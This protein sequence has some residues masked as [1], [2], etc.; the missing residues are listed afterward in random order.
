MGQSMSRGAKYFSYPLVVFVG[1]LPPALLLP[2]TNA[3]AADAPTSK[4]AAP[5]TPKKTP[6]SGKNTGK[7]NA[8]KGSARSA[9]TTARRQV[10]GGPTSDDVSAGHESPELRALREAER[11]LFPPASPAGGGAWPTELPSPLS[12]PSDRPHVH[13]SG[14][15]PSPVP[16]APPMSEGGKDL[17]WMQNLQLP[18]FPIRW[19]PRV[20]RYLEFFKDDPRGRSS[21]TI[22][23]RR[24]GRFRQLMSRALRKK[25]VPEDLFWLS[26]IESGFDPAARSPVGA[27]GLWQFMPETGKQYGLLQDRWLDQRLQPQAA[28]DAAADFL[29]DL[30]RRFGSWELAMASYNMGYAGVISMVRKYNTNDYW[31]LSRLEGALPWETTLYVPKIMAAAIVG[32]NLATFG[33][34]DVAVESAADYE[35]VLVPPGTA[36]STV[37]TACGVPTKEITDLNLELRAQRTPPLDPA[38]PKP[39][40]EATTPVGYP[41][42]VPVG[43]GQQGTQNLA[44]QKKDASPPER[45]VVRFGESLEQISAAR[46]VPLA[47]IVELNAIAQ[48]EVVRGGTVILL[49]SAKSAP[50]TTI[51]ASTPAPAA[52]KPIVIVPADVFV[53]PDRRRVFYRVIVGDTLRDI[54][55]TFKISVDEIRRWNEIDPVGRLQEGMTLQLFVPQDADL[56]KVVAMAETDVRTVPVGTDDFFTYWEG[57]KG[58]RRI[59]IPAKTGDTLE[60]IGKRYGVTPASMERVNRRN[61]GEALKEGDVVVVYLPANSKSPDPAAKPG[62]P[63]AP[64][65]LGPLPTAPVPS[66]LP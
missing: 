65:P 30:H 31:S 13:A 53:Y 36:L 11:E 19:E 7:A 26:M 14:L 50:A 54:A 39:T 28:T 56:S 2:T 41:V 27:L 63:S 52:D 3:H 10:A 37:A 35:E 32:R 49:P 16:S 51:T 66:A 20:V 64:D 45:Y 29:A 55:T 61:R 15:P 18:D 46:G 57:N 40:S 48:G 33:F 38:E 4:A 43:K 58:R 25:S 47:K 42:R 12:A 1:A 59:S 60:I 9:D 6:A 34:A 8:A 22:W 62:D 44:K 23:L 21:L 17:S 5:A 24:S